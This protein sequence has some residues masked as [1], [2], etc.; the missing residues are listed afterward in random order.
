MQ[1]EIWTMLIPFCRPT[2][3]TKMVEFREAFHVI[4]KNPAYLRVHTTCLALLLKPQIWLS[5]KESLK[6]KQKQVSE[7]L[8]GK[9]CDRWWY[10]ASKI[11]TWKP[12]R[13]NYTNDTIWAKSRWRSLVIQDRSVIMQGINSHPYEKKRQK[14]TLI[15]QDVC[16]IQCYLLLFWVE[17]GFFLPVSKWQWIRCV[18]SLSIW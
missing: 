13:L 5:Y 15:N 2:D 7:K 4:H 11:Y 12:L 3:L 6:S 17:N 10:V 1:P 9:G 16:V 8:W 18:M 14:V